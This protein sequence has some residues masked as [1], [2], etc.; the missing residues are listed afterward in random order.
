MKQQIVPAGK[1]Q[2]YDWTRDHVYV[3]TPMDFTDG[4]VTVVE[5]TLKP[6]FDLARHYH[7]KMVE[8]FY[9]LEGEVAFKFDDQPDAV[10]S[11]PG[12]TINIPPHVW[13]RV[14]SAKG[15]KL[16]TIFTPGGFDKYLAEMLPLSAL[17]SADET[18][19]TALA[20]KYDS[21]MR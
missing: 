16:I 1:G 7:K 20:E 6:G 17:Q 19:M 11:T 15:A 13:H 3:K 18:F 9:I 14:T 10:I 5:D 8:I 4:R 12:M 2:D 21:W